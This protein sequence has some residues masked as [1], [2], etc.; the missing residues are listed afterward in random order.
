MFAT[1]RTRITRHTSRSGGRVARGAATGRRSTAP[2]A[3]RH[4]A[5]HRADTGPA[6]AQRRRRA[7]QRRP[8]RAHGGRSRLPRAVG[9][10]A[11]KVRALLFR[12]CLRA[13]C[14]QPGG[15]S[16]ALLRATALELAILAG[17]LLLY[18]SGITPE[19]R[20]ARPT[21]RPTGPPSRRP[22]PAAALPHRPQAPHTRRSSCCTASSTTAPSSSC[23]AAPSPGTAGSHLECAQL[24]PADLRHPHRRRA[25]RPAHRGDLRAH[26]A[27]TRSTSS[28]TAS[29][30]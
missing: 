4:G 20:A 29:A 10:S 12:R 17:H 30:G 1:R 3:A 7:S 28:G 2:S 27:S 14:R 21:P 25:A 11:M 15:L 5:A 24:L 13:C 19:R 23:C 9:R 18:P 6:R 22:A 26:R 16:A 8:M